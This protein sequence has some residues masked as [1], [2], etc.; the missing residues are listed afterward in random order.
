M[1]DEQLDG[2]A[3][4]REFL[5]HSPFARELGLALDSIEA[6]RAE[7]VLP[8][9]E[10]LATYAD[11]VHGGAICALV[12]VAATAAAWSDIEP[13]ASPQGATVGLT[14]DFLRAA[15][16]VDLRARARVVRRGRQLCFCDVEV[17]RPDEELVAKG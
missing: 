11:V 4:M 8:F 14:V 5:A 1:A 3:L 10:G 12:D 16:G 17:I 13:S 2:A 9:R 6:D 15:R 7:L